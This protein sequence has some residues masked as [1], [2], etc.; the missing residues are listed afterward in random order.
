MKYGIK[1]VIWR[2]IVEA[3]DATAE[4]VAHFVD[5]L[6]KR[7]IIDPQINEAVSFYTHTIVDAIFN[8]L[9]MERIRAEHEKRSKSVQYG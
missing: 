5:E 9:V 7:G 3:T 6:H 2:R 4:L 8:E 1:D